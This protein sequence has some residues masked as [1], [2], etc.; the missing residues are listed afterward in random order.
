MDKMVDQN[1]VIVSYSKNL[2][3]NNKT[4]SYASLIQNNNNNASNGSYVRTIQPYNPSNTTS[5]ITPP[6]NIS[7]NVSNTINLSPQDL[8]G[9]FYKGQDTNTIN[10]IKQI[11]N[12]LTLPE[13]FNLLSQYGININDL[14]NANISFD[15]GKIILKYT[16]S[17]PLT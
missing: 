17:S 9:P 11:L 8:L 6:T 4:N 14:K 3:V 15:N 7:S 13:L 2:T 1:K 10:Q 12:G 5:M 16:Y